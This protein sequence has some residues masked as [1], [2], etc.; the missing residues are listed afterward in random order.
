MDE[1]KL[2]E[3]LKRIMRMIGSSLGVMNLSRDQTKFFATF[4]ADAMKVFRIVDAKL[5]AA[6]KNLLGTRIDYAYNGL[7]KMKTFGTD[8]DLTTIVANYSTLVQAEEDVDAALPIQFTVVVS[9]F[10]VYDQKAVS[11][12]VVSSY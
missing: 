4:D 10:E 8:N 3:N 12:S 5:I 9:E 6:C 1:A 11:I 2:E 7:K